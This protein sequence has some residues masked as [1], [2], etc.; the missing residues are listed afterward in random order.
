LFHPTARLCNSAR[1]HPSNTSALS[2]ARINKKVEIMTCAM[3]LGATFCRRERIV[4]TKLFKKFI[5]SLIF[6]LFLLD[7]IS[8]RPLSGCCG[9]K[10]SAATRGDK[11]CLL[12]A[13][14]YM[15]ALG[16]N[17]EMKRFTLSVRALYLF[18]A[19]SYIGE[20]KFGYFNAPE[21]ILANLIE[22]LCF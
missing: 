15:E 13:A 20:S 2:A 9:A 11:L 12:S 19:H 18:A 16:I 14:S 22:G 6:L 4:Q 1:Q 8:P 5:A 7:V 3:L 10:I 21:D 17:N